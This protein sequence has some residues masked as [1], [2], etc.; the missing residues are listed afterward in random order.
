M[1]YLFY[2]EF[3]QHFKVNNLAFFYF[4]IFITIIY[5]ITIGIPI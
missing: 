5:F 3:K 4:F 1:A 2:I